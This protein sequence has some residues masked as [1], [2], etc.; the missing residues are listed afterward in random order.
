ML[1]VT[2]LTGCGNRQP[3][4]ASDNNQAPSDTEQSRVRIDSIEQAKDHRFLIQLADKKIESL[5]EIIPGFAQDER[6]MVLVC[7]QFNC[8]SCIESGFEILT[9]VKRQNPEMKT[10]AVGITKEIPYNSDTY[11]DRVYEDEKGGP[12]CRIKLCSAA[13]ITRF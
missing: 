1:A 11:T 13:C 2:A 8:I 9:A 4:N 12:P 3:N 6:K 5:N 7:S 10:Y